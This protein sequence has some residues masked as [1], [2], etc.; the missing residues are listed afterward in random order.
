M[1]EQM[2]PLEKRRRWNSEYSKRNRDKRNESQRRYRESNKELI[3]SYRI[4]N[5]EYMRKNKYKRSAWE[6]KRRLSKINRTPKW[7]TKEDYNAMELI[8]KEA[9][10]L[11]KETGIKHH[12][13]HIIPL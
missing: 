13:D 8:Y 2:T 5:A 10:R 4:K 1:V 12:V 9:H 7:L 6:A 3:R 11:T